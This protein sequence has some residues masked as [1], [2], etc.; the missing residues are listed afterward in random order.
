MPAVLLED[1]V[2]H[3]GEDGRGDGHEH[4]IAAVDPP[5]V[6]GIAR[7]PSSCE[8]APVAAPRVLVERSGHTLP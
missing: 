2:E 8:R 7:E 3:R 6:V 5:L 1:V 4:E